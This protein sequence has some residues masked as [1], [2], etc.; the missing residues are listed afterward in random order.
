MERLSLI[1]QAQH[2]FRCPLCLHQI[3]Q[4]NAVIVLEH[5]V[6]H[7]C[8]HLM[9]EATAAEIGARINDER[10]NDWVGTQGI[11]AYAPPRHRL[12]KHAYHLER[13][14]TTS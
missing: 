7:T 6:C 12:G 10:D 8:A 2:P 11:I 3:R 4:Q 9:T 13:R 14:D 1:L 5:V